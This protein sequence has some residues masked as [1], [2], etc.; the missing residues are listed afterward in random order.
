MHIHLSTDDVWGYIRT[1]TH[2][3]CIYTHIYR[4]VSMYTPLR[5]MTTCTHT[6]IHVHTYASDALFPWGCIAF[7]FRTERRRLAVGCSSLLLSPRH[8]AAMQRYGRAGGT[9][10]ERGNGLAAL[11][12]AR[13]S[14]GLCK[15][16]QRRFSVEHAEVFTY[17]ARAVSLLTQWFVYHWQ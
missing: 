2:I 8:A 15:G 16:R 11:S 17:R 14:P 3:R 6:R 1:C 12:E 5:W 13:I 9:A 4:Y 10:L 7:P